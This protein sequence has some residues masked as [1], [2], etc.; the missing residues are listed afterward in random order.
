MPEGKFD[1][2]AGGGSS[3]DSESDSKDESEVEPEVVEP[4]TEEES[5]IEA[6]P[7]YEYA[8]SDNVVEDMVTYTRSKTVKNEQQFSLCTF[9]YIS[10]HMGSPKHYIAGVLIGTAGSGKSHLQNTVSNLIDPSIK[11]E[12]TSGS[13]KSI[14]YDR[15][16]WNASMIADLDELQKPSEDI[17]EILKGLHGGEDDSFVYKVTS[18]GEGADRGTDEIELDAMPYWFLYAQFEPDF[19]MWD[20]LLKVPVHESSQKN[21]GVARTHWGH[22]HITFGDSGKEYDFDFEDGEKALKSHIKNL[23]KNAYV[24]IPA[25]EEEF[26]GYSFYD[27]VKGIFDIDRSETNRVSKM[28]AN[29]V[30]CSALMNYKNREKRQ[31]RINNMGVKNVFI[32]E[33]QDLANVMAC[34]D[35]LMATTHQLDKKRRIICKAIEEVGGTSNAAPIKHPGDKPGNPQSIM[36]YLRETDSSFV[37]KSQITQMLAD[38]EDNG[39]VEK[40]ENAGENRRHLYQFTSWSNLGKFDID[41]D[42]KD[43]FEDTVDPF[44]NQPFIETARDI[45]STLTPSAS[46]FMTE[47]NV[48]SS[49]NESVGQSSLTGSTNE[50]DID[51]EPY[52]EAVHSR[53][54]DTVDG[55][56]LDNLD[57]HDPTPREL[58]GFVPIGEPD[59]EADISG[60]II[61]PDHEVWAYGPDEWI[62]SVTDAEEHI[63]KALR[64]LTVEGVFKTSIIESRGDQPVKM[65]VQVDEIA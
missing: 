48:S 43:L 32:A 38:L 39:L 45:N 26:G 30:R 18:D 33:P 52:E 57:E 59:D 62:E 23:P 54:K 31:M 49:G 5:A 21:D 36:G 51:L 4:L 14:I 22:S 9:G 55:E 27:E 12:A 50:Q 56:T 24:H 7:S 40:L 58:L 11:Y 61:D 3:D 25:G 44:E 64:N 17:I 1:I 19:E 34:R 13:D 53:L 37:K 10:G 20:R 16:N 29:L 8:L 6:E 60:T 15:E 65:D 35:V 41:E 47:K 28:V 46:D 2:T 63:E 42:F